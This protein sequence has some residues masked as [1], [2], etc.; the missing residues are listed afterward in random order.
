MQTVD[1]IISVVRLKK[2]QQV[3]IFSHNLYEFDKELH[4]LFIEFKQVCDY[5]NR[6]QLWAVLNNIEI[7]SKLVILV[8]SCN[9]NKMCQ[10]LLYFQGN[11]SK[12]FYV[13]IGLRKG[14]NCLQYYLTWH[15][16]KW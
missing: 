12:S 15:Y 6:N 9:K 2:N 13:K 5:I 8:K 1:L 11:K 4:L 14:T 16:I 10:V 3:T 7:P